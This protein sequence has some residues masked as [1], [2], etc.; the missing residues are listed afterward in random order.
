MNVDGDP[1]QPLNPK[2]IVDGENQVQQMDEEPESI[3]FNILDILV[4]EQIYKK[5]DYDKIPEN[6]IRKL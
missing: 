2:I 4:L 3:D 1:S 6:H 5:R